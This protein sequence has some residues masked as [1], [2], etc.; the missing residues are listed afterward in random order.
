MGE[1]AMAAT[2]R[3]EQAVYMVMFLL[4]VTGT[5]HVVR[6]VNVDGCLIV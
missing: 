3:S 5:D 1:E 6:Q 4:R 2:L